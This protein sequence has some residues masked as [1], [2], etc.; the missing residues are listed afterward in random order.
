[1]TDSDPTMNPTPADPL[2]R[3]ATAWR[4]LRLTL[5]LLIAAHGLARWQAAAVRPFGDWLSSQGWPAGLALA[6]GITLLE[7]L[8]PA[9]LAA[10]RGTRALC[11]AFAALYAMG[12][13]LV[14][15]P[16]GWFVVGLGRNGAEYS[17]L[18]IV[19]LLLLAWQA[20]AGLAARSN[21]SSPSDP[22]R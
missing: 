17:V 3:S 5:A 16:A 10:E 6:W 21:P 4:L 1:M 8:G 22:T 9:L 7:I 2:R 11:L 14:H 13:V 15:A 19:C 12:I 20:P 18:L